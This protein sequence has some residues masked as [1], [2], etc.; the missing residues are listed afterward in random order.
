MIFLPVLLSAF[1]HLWKPIDFPFGP[2]ND[3]S[4]YLRRAMY[5]L[6][7]FGPQQ[8]QFYDHPFFAQFFLA[9]IFKIVG[10][11]NS[12][13]PSANG[14]EHSIETL[15]LLPKIIAGL[16]AVLDTILIYKITQI[17]YNRNAAFLASLLFAVMPITGELRW[18]L[19]EP[20]QLPFILSSILFAIFIGIKDRSGIGNFAFVLL[21][22]I[23]LGL[24]IFTKIPV[25]TMIPLVGFLII[26]NS[27]KM[28]LRSILLWFIP[29]ILIPLIWP[30]Y[31]ISI[32]QF[33]QWSSGVYTQTH[34]SNHTFLSSIN[35]NFI[36]DPLFVG[37]SVIA[38]LFILFIKRDLF[39]ALWV[40]PFLFLLYIVGFV[41]LWHFIPILPACCIAVAKF[42]LD[43]TS[44]ITT[45]K[46]ILLRQSLPFIV[47]SAIGFFG[48]FS[49]ITMIA[50]S[51][52]SH[53]F[54]AAAFVN[55][56]LKNNENNTYNFDNNNNLNSK[57]TVTGNPFYLWIPE[58]VF[59]FHADYIGYYENNKP[60][61]TKKI[62]EIMD[63]GLKSLLA[64]NNAAK[65]IQAMNDN[66]NLYK[67][68]RIATFIGKTQNK[69]DI[70]L[71]YGI[72]QGN[73][74]NIK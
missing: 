72:N 28:K 26:K 22:G 46:R 34:R 30:A 33:S 8:G 11:P 45:K 42:I 47:I 29:V 49:T 2:S 62:L 66:P 1:T 38:L 9:G 48:L 18:V 65:Q 32:G 19:L 61:E 56:Y 12:F 54:K 63:T 69:I 31:A 24:A 70:L 15:Y 44:L 68:N 74:N 3:E 10:Y 43:I 16:L 14:D 39:I 51:D 40:A 41:S 55:Q 7:G 5:V 73:N 53:F 23:F 25:F 4:I 6:N 13:H 64:R 60:I 21:S 59:H 57:I 67:V 27:K 20:I 17:L 35:Y 36:I 71:I 37:L 50:P 52:N 58:Y